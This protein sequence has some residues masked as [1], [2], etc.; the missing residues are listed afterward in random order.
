MR[1]FVRSFPGDMPAR[2]RAPHKRAQPVS[3]GARTPWNPKK[4]G[5]GRPPAGVRSGP[6]LPQQSARLVRLPNRPGWLRLRRMTRAWRNRWHLM[7]V[8]DCRP[9]C[10]T[11]TAIG[12]PSRHFLKETCAGRTSDASNRDSNRDAGRDYRSWIAGNCP[13]CRLHVWTTP[14][15]TSSRP[16]LWLKRR[17]R[18]ALP[19]TINATSAVLRS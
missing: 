17:G 2:R 8:P 14:T 13:S 19:K 3:T 12:V 18:R 10:R 4:S 7:A 16:R 11:V 6:A 5:S 1:T 15:L 9:D